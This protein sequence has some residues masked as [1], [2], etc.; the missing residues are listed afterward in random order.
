MAKHQ[1]T[2]ILLLLILGITLFTSVAL[3]SAKTDD[4]VVE[5]ES[6]Y[7]LEFT[8]HNHDDAIG[9]RGKLVF[10]KYFAP[11]CGHCKNLAPTWKALAEEF[12]DDL[13]VDIAT[14]DCTVY[15]SICERIGIKGFPT[16]KLY[17]N[18]KELETYKGPRS[19]DALKGFVEDNLQGKM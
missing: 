10:I 3:V 16:L 5:E 2:T 17:E 4:V 1:T 12:K 9:S 19:L 13:T 15:K 8:D 6:S 7:V 11:W 14:V 18:G